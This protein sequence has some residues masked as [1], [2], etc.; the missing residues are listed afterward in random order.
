[1][2]ET[3]NA[4]H[5]FQRK[6]SAK[7]TPTFPYSSESF[8]T[9]IFSVFL[10]YL[11]KK[12][13]KQSHLRVLECKNS[14]DVP[15]YKLRRDSPTLAVSGL[16]FEDLAVEP[17]RDAMCNYFYDLANATPRIAGFEP[18][19][20]IRLR[21]RQPG[22]KER[23]VFIENK[24]E[25]P[26]Q[27]NQVENYPTLVEYLNENGIE[28]EFLLLISLGNK[29]VYKQINYL[30]QHKNDNFKFGLLIWEDVLHRMKEELFH[31]PGADIAGWQKY[32]EGLQNRFD[33]D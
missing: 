11:G 32:T 17:N 24:M 31:L 33:L 4:T 21:T 22:K 13:G 29:R 26:L 8:W 14:E 9:S 3:L 1:M 15:K 6:E 5:L 25:G 12:N 19:L 23:Y 16:S 7:G 18:D 10:L 28:S 20:L 27:R 2:S 30:D